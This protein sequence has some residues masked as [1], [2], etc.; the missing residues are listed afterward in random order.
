M[1]KKK[2]MYRFVYQDVPFNRHITIFVYAKNEFQ[3]LRRFYRRLPYGTTPNIARF[4]ECPIEQ[5]TDVGDT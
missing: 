3:A 5:A 4:E 2:K 1:F